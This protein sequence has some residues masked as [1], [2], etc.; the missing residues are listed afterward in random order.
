MR[1]LKFLGLLVIAFAMMGV[2]S[3]S[4]VEF[5]SEGSS[6]V[7]T[8]SQV[9]EDVFTTTAGTVTC[10]EANYTGEQAT[11]TAATVE[12]A[13]TY[14]ECTGPSGLPATV[15]PNGCTY[16]FGAAAVTTKTHLTIVCP[17]NKE[18]TVTVIEPF[19]N[20]VKCTIH[21]PG[22]TIANA[23]EYHNGGS[24]ATRDVTVTVSTSSI[25]YSQTPGSGFGACSAVHDDNGQYTG[26]A[27]V[28]GEH[29]TPTPT[30]TG[31]WVE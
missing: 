17:K 14:G 11:S 20:V 19:F 29:G 3:A 28:T 2:S 21:V 30:H 13:P 12:V 23:V 9:G 16:K 8:G 22:Q 7:L 15:H 24:G 1:K 5:H 26:V 6:T 31:V 25:T 4:A 18:I 27:T 10:E